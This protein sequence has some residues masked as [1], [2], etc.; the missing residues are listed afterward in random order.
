MNTHIKPWKEFKSPLMQVLTFIAWHLGYYKYT[1][2]K[3]FR[4]IILSAAVVGALYL[5]LF[6]TGSHIEVHHAGEV[7]FKTGR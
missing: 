5:L 3:F 7:W 6:I 4:I 1:I 2:R